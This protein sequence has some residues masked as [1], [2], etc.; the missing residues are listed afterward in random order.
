[1]VPVPDELLMAY[2]DGEL[3]PKEAEAL[4]TLL[5]QDPT[6]RI[7]LAPFTQTRVRIASVFEHKLH[8]PVPD[9]LIAAIA[10]A[11]VAEQAR[12]KQRVSLWDQARGALQ[13]VAQAVL[14]DGRLTPALA[15][16][17]AAL[18]VVGAVAGWIA[19]RASGPAALID[20]A[21][22]GLVA[23]GALAEVLE[24]NPS[25]VVSEADA[26]GASAVPVLSFRSK[27]NGVCREYRI[28]R[29]GSAPDSAGLACRTADGVWRVALH[30]EA[31]KQ[32]Q[33]GSGPYQTAT[34]ANVP[35]VDALIETII[36]GDA[37]G[38]DD[39]TTLLGSAWRLAPAPEQRTYTPPGG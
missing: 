20:V 5:S 15:G 3:T 27:N 37:F 14:P 35:A 10:R 19:G 4:E 22:S 30:V 9:R 2:A 32:T 29:A 24:T 39:E 25:G 8:E 16:S 26:D 21:G 34:A 28:T 38:K 13:A 1:M 23:S 33:A 12:Q 17:A 36:S 18:L 7:R 6:L 11:A 31:P